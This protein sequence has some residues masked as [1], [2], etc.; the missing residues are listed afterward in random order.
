MNFNEGLP[1]AK[2]KEVIWVVIHRM[3]KYA[4]FVSLKHPFIAIEVFQLLLDNIFKIHG[5]PESIIFDRD[6][7]FLSNFWKELLALSDIDHNLSSS[8][9][10]QSYGQPKVLTCV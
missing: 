5:F 4:Y 9:H 6:K 8:Y 2:R 7:T 10:P 1:N 3:S